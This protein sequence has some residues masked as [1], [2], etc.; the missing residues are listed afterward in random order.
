VTIYRYLKSKSVNGE[1]AKKMLKHIETNFR[2]LPFAER[3]LIGVVPKDMHKTS[4]KELL[5]SKAIMKYPV[6][7]EASRKPVAQAEH[8]LLIKEDGCEVLT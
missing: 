7:V 1:A 5:S 4:F 6:F 3:W 2:T 8:T